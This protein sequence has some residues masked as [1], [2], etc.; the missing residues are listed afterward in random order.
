MSGKFKLLI[1]ALA[2]VVL[3]GCQGDDFYRKKREE[4]AEKHINE[5]KRNKV[6]VGRVFSLQEAIDYALKNNL[7]MK[8]YALRESVQNANKYSEAFKM[9]PE[10]NL[11]LDLTH[12]N[13]DAASQS[14]SIDTGDESLAFSRSTERDNQKF[15]IDI[16]FSAIDFGVSYLSAVQ[17]QDRVLLEKQLERR[18]A[19]NLMYDVAKAYF[20]VAAT[21]DAM[22]KTEKLLEKCGRIDQLLDK[23]AQERSVSSLRILDERKRFARVEE[24]LMLF[25]KKYAEASAELKSLMGLALESEI[26]VDSNVL[27]K[28]DERIFKLPDI[29][30]LEKVAL[31]ERPEL[32]QLDIQKHLVELEADKTIIKMFPNVKAFLDFTQDSN[33][34]LYNHSWLEIGLRAAYNVARLPARI[35][36]YKSYDTE[37][38]ELDIR[39]TALSF[40][41]L[42]QVRV[43]YKNIDEVYKRYQLD[44]RIYKSY[45][46]YYDT[47]KGE[48]SRGGSVRRLDLDRTELETVEAEIIRIQSVGNC[49]LAFFR[50]MNAMGLKMPRIE[51]ADERF[52]QLQ[53]MISGELPYCIGMHYIRDDGVIVYNG[54]EF[55]GIIS[56][57]E[58]LTLQEMAKR[59]FKPE[60]KVDTKPIIIDTRQLVAEVTRRVEENYRIYASL[61]EDK[62]PVKGVMKDDGTM[63]YNDVE[64][65]SSTMSKDERARLDMLPQ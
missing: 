60:I 40:G 64:V 41:V 1:A 31:R 56:G 19:Q 4:A 52:A 27:D 32:Y 17:A 44:N 9:L 57:K 58:R 43:A 22:G 28:V 18:A 65:K 42:S 36:Q 21:Q 8:V 51:D 23:I 55:E 12:R 48:F 54:I 6:E 16:A 61:P 47:M 63:V 5:I 37:R 13:N 10:A 14:I 46:A 30:F 29:Y 35:A 15:N 39:T 53:N 20:T 45:K 25:R 34:F 49:Y 62:L 11:S 24:A 33:K 59:G 7:D 2:S 26:K 50:L 38:R 3:L